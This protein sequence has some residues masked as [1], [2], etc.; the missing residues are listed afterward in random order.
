[1]RLAGIFALAL[2]ALAPQ[3]ASAQGCEI[4]RLG[5]DFTAG[6][7]SGSAP[8]EGVLCYDLRFGQGQ[9]I[10]VE[11][12]SG[13]NVTV[14]APG[15]YDARNDRM[16]LGDLPGRLELRVFQLMRS[17]TPQPFALRIRFEPPG[18]G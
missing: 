9:N 11:L 6:D 4:V 3:A 2:L 8:A 7:L 16:Y 15:Y 5:A 1:M 18:N 14:S 13:E 10:S 12:V 17:A